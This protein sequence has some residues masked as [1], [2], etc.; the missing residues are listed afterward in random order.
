MISSKDEVYRYIEEVF[1]RMCREG[2]L[3]RTNQKRNGQTVYVHPELATP[4]EL[5]A[6]RRNKD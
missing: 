1:E 4:E 3:V 6:Q 2:E 5:E